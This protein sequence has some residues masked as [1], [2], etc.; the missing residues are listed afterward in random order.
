MSRFSLDKAARC[1]GIPVY[2]FI[3]TEQRT[4]RSFAFRTLEC[5]ARFDG[6]RLR[7]VRNDLRFIWVR[8]LPEN[9]GQDDAHLRSCAL[10]VKQS[11]I[12]KERLS[13]SPQRSTMKLLTR[14]FAHVGSALRICCV[15]G[16]NV[17]VARLNSHLPFDCRTVTR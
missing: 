7:P 10:D 16:L 14:E 5:L 3:D 9:L 11:W 13:Y 4:R 2:A 17:R 1:P 15:Q 6:V 12:E 8:H